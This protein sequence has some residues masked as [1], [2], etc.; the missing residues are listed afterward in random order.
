MTDKKERHPDEALFDIDEEPVSELVEAFERQF[1]QEEAEQIL[2][3]FRG[4]VRRASSLYKVL[5]DGYAGS[6]SVEDLIKAGKNET[7]TDKNP[8]N[9]MAETDD[10]ALLEAW[11]SDTPEP[12]V[13][14]LDEGHEY[15]L[16]YDE[17]DGEPKPAAGREMTK[18]FRLMFAVPDAEL[19]SFKASLVEAGF[20][21]VF[22][23]QVE[24]NNSPD[25]DLTERL[26]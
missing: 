18:K 11:G 8:H 10:E 15:F 25:D 22:S 20:A 1:S 4:D 9:V 14:G 5:T 13:N 2:E 17:N 7:M 24:Y 26:F 12:R 6:M 3:G 23:E 16:V 19:E 21:P